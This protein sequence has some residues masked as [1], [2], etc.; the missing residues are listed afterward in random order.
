M[1][2]SRWDRGGERL[3]QGYVHRAPAAISLY[4]AFPLR[5]VLHYG[6]L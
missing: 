4:R 1:A 2:L 6:V 3:G 5:W